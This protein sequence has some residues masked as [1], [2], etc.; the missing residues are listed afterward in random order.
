MI[1]YPPHF[2][3]ECV[4]MP[5]LAFIIRPAL[6]FLLLYHFLYCGIDAFVGSII[7]RSVDETPESF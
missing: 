6:Q 1:V 7:C 5:I 2:Q 4:H 3:P